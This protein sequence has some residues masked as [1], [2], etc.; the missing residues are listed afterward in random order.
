MEYYYNERSDTLHCKVKE[1]NGSHIG[2]SYDT[3]VF[4]YIDDCTKSH[5]DL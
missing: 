4:V 5:M 1:G 3:L 2:H